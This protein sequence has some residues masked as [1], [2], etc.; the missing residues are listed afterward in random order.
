[1]IVVQFNVMFF[2]TN[3]NN[4]SKPWDPDVLVQEIV[5]NLFCEPISASRLAHF[6]DDILL[7][8]HSAAMWNQE[9]NLFKQTG[10]DSAVKPRL[11][12]LIRGIVQTPEFQLM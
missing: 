6:R 8:N 11:E 7:N 2:V 9:W 12:A 3:P 10:N 1:M 4:I 5:D